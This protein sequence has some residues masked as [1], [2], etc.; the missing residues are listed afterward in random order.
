MIGYTH[1]HAHALSKKKSAPEILVPCVVAPLEHPLK[2]SCA[3]LPNSINIPSLWSVKKT[4]LIKAHV[5]RGYYR[6]A[7]LKSATQENLPTFVADFTEADT[8]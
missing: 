1:A 3:K 6:L 4:L 2:P 7:L 5:C 8:Q